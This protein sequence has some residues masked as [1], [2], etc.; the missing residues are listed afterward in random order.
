MEWTKFIFDGS[1][2]VR[3]IF[4][5]FQIVAMRSKSGVQGIGLLGLL[6]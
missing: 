2:D 6:G 5:Y 4:L 3:I 1:A